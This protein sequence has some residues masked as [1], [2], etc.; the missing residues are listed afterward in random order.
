M[1]KKLNKE[2]SQAISFDSIEDGKV[3]K[4]Q[5]IAISIRSTCLTDLKQSEMKEGI[6][7]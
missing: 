6:K 3:I 1:L 7:E 4:H 5:T 2:H